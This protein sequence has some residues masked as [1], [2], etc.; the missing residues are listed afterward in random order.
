MKKANLVMEDKKKQQQ[1]PTNQTSLNLEP[2]QLLEGKEASGLSE[3]QSLQGLLINEFHSLRDLIDKRYTMLEERYSK[4]EDTIGSQ[5]EAVTSDIQKL[6]N[7]LTEHKKE[8]T[9]EVN[10][11]I[12]SNTA[13]ISVILEEKKQL[14]LQNINL[15]ERLNKI[16]STQL[17]NNVMIT[18]LPEQQWEPHQTTKKY[19]HETI[20]ATLTTSSDSQEKALAL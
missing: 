2:A 4:L 1:A 16:E 8:V 3:L 7:I 13:N 10:K 9:G 15:I 18:G 20:A 6:E 14:K 17:S 11:K 19:V 5:N 12:D